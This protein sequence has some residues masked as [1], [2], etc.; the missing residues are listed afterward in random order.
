MIS[1]RTFFV[2]A[3]LYIVKTEIPVLMI[4]VIPCTDASM[5][6][7]LLP[8][9]MVSFVTVLICAMR[10]VVFSTQVTPAR[11]VTVTK[12]KTC[13]KILVSSLTLEIFSLPLQ[14]NGP[15][16]SALMLLKEVRWCLGKMLPIP[17]QRIFSGAVTTKYT[18]GGDPFLGAVATHPWPRRR[19]P[20]GSIGSIAANRASPMSRSP[21]GRR[22]S[23]PRPAQP[24]RSS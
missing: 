3:L 18:C 13:V 1:V 19:F 11:N 5:I 8:A 6:I 12:K 23:A 22:A 24:R 2:R 4:Y 17:G 15:Y 14:E 7:M 10:V 20:P 9:M 16:Q 21:Y